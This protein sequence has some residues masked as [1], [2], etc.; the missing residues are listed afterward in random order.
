MEEKKKFILAIPTIV[1][2]ILFVIIMSFLV[3][4]KNFKP[5]SKQ[6]ALEL[7]EK[8]L[9]IDNISCEV[10]TQDEGEHIVDYK[11]KDNKL[12]IINDNYFEYVDGDTSNCIYI[13]NSAKEVYKYSSVSEID[14]FKSLIGVSVG[15]LDNNDYEYKFLKYE[16]LNG[17]KCA[18]IQLTNSDTKIVL[19]IDRDTGMTVKVVGDYTSQDSENAQ[20]T[21]LYR[22]QIGKVKDDDLKIPDTTD[23]VVME[24]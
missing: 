6:E 22:Y 8:S 1:I 3:Y 19:W 24:Y 12:V 21:N 10:V 20:I 11:F 14:G 15:L 5:L 17:I 7:A 9:S 4:R 23:Y 2:I 18:K 13:D 16:K